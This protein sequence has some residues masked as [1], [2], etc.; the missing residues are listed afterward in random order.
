MSA[1]RLLVVA[2]VTLGT[3]ENGLLS[4]PAWELRGVRRGTLERL[5]KAGGHLQHQALCQALD[6]D[7]LN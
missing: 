4:W 6:K 3:E 7:F 1:N 5:D 2:R